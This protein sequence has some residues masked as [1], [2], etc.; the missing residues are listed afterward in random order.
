MSVSI[1]QG[2]PD[3]DA[4][5]AG[6]DGFLTRIKEWQAKKAAAEEALTA[7][8]IGKDAA[9]ALSAAQAE[10]QAA[11]QVLEDAK[12]QAETILLDAK[13]KAEEVTKSAQSQADTLLA[14]AHKEAAGLEEEVSAARKA[15]Q[16]WS[17]KTKNEANGHLARAVTARTAADKQ[18]SDNQ[19][20]AMALADSRVGLDAALQAA[21]AKKADLD[22]RLEAIRAA[23]S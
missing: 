3:L 5:V 18:L 15:L 22:A 13:R 17:E 23:A 7:L 8:N 10:R 2:N 21:V 20:A 9:A 6:G 1:T 14:S 11:I 12:S 16:E 19:T 4:M